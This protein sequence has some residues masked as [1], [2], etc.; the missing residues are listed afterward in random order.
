MRKRTSLLTCFL[1]F[2]TFTALAQEGF[3]L[4]TTN[5]PP[6]E[7]SKRRASVYDAIGSSSLALIQGAA[8]P[9]GYTRFRQSNEFYYLCGV[10]TPHSYLLLDGAQR[11][12]TLY[13]PHRNEGRER[14]EGK[15]LSAEDEPLII[16]LAGVDAVYGIDILPEHLARSAR[17]NTLRTLFTPFNPAEGAAMSRDLAVRSLGDAAADPFDGRA[18]REGS[19]IQLVRSRFPQF[20]MRDLSPLLD[21]L[22]LI[23]SPREIAVIQKATQLAGLALM[24]CMRSTK[25]GIMEYEL[26]AV[27]KYVYYRNGAQGEAY[28]SL[29]QS[30]P[31]A[32][33]GH[34]NAGKRQMRD[35]DF[36]LMDF[37]PDY[38]YYMSDLTRMWPVNGKFSSSQRELY[39]F[40]AGCYRAL[41]K[42]IKP[43]LTAQAVLQ[44]AVREM[45]DILVKMI[46]SKPLYNQAAKAFVETFRQSSKNP[47]AMLGHW[48]GMSTHDVGQDIG[49][50][51][52]GM[53]FTI[54]PAFQIREEQ[55][56]IRCEDLIVITENGA[57]ILSDFVPLTIDQ[58][59][60][61]MAGDGLLQNYPRAT[62]VR[63]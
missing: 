54:E 53:V 59:E 32:M 57:E 35:G 50:L 12:A 61:Q 62:T 5:F 22:R 58:I 49:P 25:P 38:G 17:G 28:Y 15:V 40:Y 24:E 20:D 43:G 27:A 29:V 4:F 48:V 30:G 13:L 21:N 6:E 47:R 23:K 44:A 8:V 19:L 16:Q 55:I 56:N 1:V 42:A 45:D 52:A 3:S 37:A 31:N 60:K 2:A 7:F 36:L 9:A 34:Y 63:K 10:E 18:S 51:R 11:R 39:E 14:A 46:F 41:L 33:L 26:D